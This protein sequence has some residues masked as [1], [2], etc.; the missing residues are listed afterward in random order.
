MELGKLKTSE[1]WNIMCL[2]NCRLK[3]EEDF[4]NPTKD[5]REYYD[6]LMSYVE[7]DPDIAFD[8]PDLED[9]DDEI[10]ALRAWIFDEE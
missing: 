5:Q 9:M 3:L 6:Y 10:E 8:M 4:P 2:V 1:R 7:K